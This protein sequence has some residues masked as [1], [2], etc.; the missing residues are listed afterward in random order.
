MTKEKFIP[1]ELGKLEKDVAE[2]L[3]RT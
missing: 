1:E 3:L 2:Y